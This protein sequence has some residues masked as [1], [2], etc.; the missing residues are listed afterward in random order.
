[1]TRR[2][3]PKTHSPDLPAPLVRIRAIERV[4]QRIAT[5]P[6]AE[7]RLGIAV[8]TQAILDSRSPV[9][10][11]Q[12]SAREFLWGRGMEAW[13]GAID[14][15]PKFVRELA[16]RTYYLPPRSPAPT[17]TKPANKRRNRAGLQFGRFID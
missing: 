14:L 6:P 2:I 15:N 4:L 13:A 3:R 9:N 1:M 17:A 10:A 12:R 7:S 16:V 8:I 11:I 5:G